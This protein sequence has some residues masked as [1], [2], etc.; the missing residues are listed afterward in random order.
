MHEF[1]YLSSSNLAF[2]EFY[3]MPYGEKGDL[4][5]CSDNICLRG[6]IQNLLCIFLRMEWFYTK[7]GSL[8][9]FLK[10]NLNKEIGKGFTSDW[11]TFGPQ[12]T[13]LW[14]CG[15]LVV[16]CHLGHRL[17]CGPLSRP[18]ARPTRRGAPWCGRRTHGERDGVV[19][20]G[21]PAV[22]V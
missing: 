1:L 14:A 18:Q 9:D 7:F 8:D 5:K 2:L 22:K 15:P 4:V 12:P 3:I 20:G 6:F 17:A 21:P 10:F 13:A 19:S 11:A 16:T